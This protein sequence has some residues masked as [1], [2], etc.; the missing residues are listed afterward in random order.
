MSVISLPP[1]ATSSMKSMKTDIF[2][3]PRTQEFVEEL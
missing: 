3:F 2:I 1:L